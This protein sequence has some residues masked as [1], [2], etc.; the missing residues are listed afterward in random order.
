[1]KGQPGGKN[2]A[3]VLTQED[4]FSTSLITEIFGG[5][6][7]SIV[8]KQGSTASARIEPFFC[9][10]LY[11]DNDTVHSLTDAFNFLTLKEKL[12]GYMGAKGVEVQAS[13]QL[14]LDKLP[15]IFL[16]HLK[17]FAYDKTTQSTCKVRKLVSFPEILRISN[18]WTVSSSS[19]ADDRDYK[20]F[21]VISHLGLS[22]QGG[23]YTCDIH[24][25]HHTNQWV[26][27]DDHKVNNIESNSVEN[28]VF[29]NS[30]AYILFYQRI[31]K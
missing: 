21:A 14:K 1:M 29:N 24:Q 23:H 26:H 30:N 17:R 25:Q 20:L 16:I 27:F 22:H 6:T 4:D 9:L 28:V 12:E 10:P 11:I 31:T 7:Q 18:T 19:S 8:S 13:K 5:T 3:I 2:K 15:L